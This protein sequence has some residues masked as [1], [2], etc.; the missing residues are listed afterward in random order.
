ML[1]DIIVTVP[2]MTGVALLDGPPVK[3]QPP[4]L[5]T[6]AGKKAKEEKSPPTQ[7]VSPLI[8]CYVPC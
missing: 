3:V 7:L 8:A 4:D 1:L 6:K 2:L 5:T